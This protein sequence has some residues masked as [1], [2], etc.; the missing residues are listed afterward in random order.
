MSFFRGWEVVWCS[1]ILQRVSTFA[2]AS[3][4]SDTEVMANVLVGMKELEDN[5]NRHLVAWTLSKWPVFFI[6]LATIM[7]V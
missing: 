5:M 6:S 7:M 2:G 3:P 4:A 1:C